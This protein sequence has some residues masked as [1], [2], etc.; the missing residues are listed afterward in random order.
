VSRRAR[1]TVFVLGALSLAFAYVLAA[2]DLPRFG[3]QTHHPY[4]DRAVHAAL[5]HRTANAV[6]SLAF[7]Q[8]GFDT[9][10]EESIL[11]LAVVAGTVL[12]R[13]Q[14]DESETQAQEGDDDE[15]G[16]ELRR[17]E[18]ADVVRLVGY[19]VLPITLVVGGY[20]VA[21]GALS[22]GGGFQ[23]GV[24]IAT[25]IHLLYV[26]GDYAALEKLRPVQLF[27]STE[28]AGVTAYVALGAVAIATGSAFLSNVLPWGSYQTLLSAGTVD[29]LNVAAGV[30]VLSGVVV[31]LS[32]FLHQALLVADEDGADA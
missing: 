23:G 6:T 9:L 30:A 12:L 26:A 22:P 19:L 31:L 20:L 3:N 28:A 8:R 13:R 1:L 7:D 32:E 4:G 14:R 16:L 25:A 10:G 17:G 5:S 11:V 27:E 24:A 29:L 18:T 15:G 21:H 2:G